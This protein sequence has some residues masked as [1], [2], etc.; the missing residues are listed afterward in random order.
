MKERNSAMKNKRS[1]RPSTMSLE[2][3][4]TR[5]SEQDNISLGDLAAEAMDA[6]MSIERKRF[7]ASEA[8]GDNKGNG[9]YTRTATILTQKVSLRV[10][11]D[12]KSAFSPMMLEVMKR[13]SSRMDTLLLTLYARGL[14]QRDIS[15]ALRD[16]YGVS[17]SP[18]RIAGLVKAFEP[19]RMAWQ[20][21]TLKSDYHIIMIDGIRISVRRDTVEK[22]T[23]YII[24]GVTPEFRR[25]ILGIHVVPEESA[26]AWKEILMDLRSRGVKRV[27]LVCSDELAG[28]EN[29]I[30][31]AFPDTAIQFCVLHKLRTLMNAVRASKKKEC[32]AAFWKVFAIDRAPDTYNDVARRLDA[33]L[34]TWGSLY[35]ALKKKLA[36][37]RLRWYVAYLR[38]PPS[39][40]RM[41]YTT[42][43]I[44]RL[45]RDVRRVTRHALS[46][47]NVDSLLNAV[48]MVM[49][50]VEEKTYTH[51]I[52]SF[53]GVRKEMEEILYERR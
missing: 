22:E 9:Y 29:A 13:E 17:C 52:T 39:A 23:V 21:R 36:P 33:F 35:P 25:E 37:E 2:A 38:Y 43:W 49:A 6:L 10:P 8:Q 16:V 20:K 50:H 47:P 24:L 11:R 31:S 42:N 51:P 53:Y 12:R 44:E 26:S 14:S 46:Y 3:M 48:F 1:T 41:L 4:F 19:T 45:N 27:G 5:L 30:L 15:E 28:I 34:A 40:R 7:L 32:A 18:S